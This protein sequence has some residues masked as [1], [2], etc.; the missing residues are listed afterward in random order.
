MNG[1]SSHGSFHLF[2]VIK[3]KSKDRT[4]IMC[5]Q[6]VQKGSRVASRNELRSG[7]G[8]CLRGRGRKGKGYL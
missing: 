5:S 1:V 4:A 3:K 2:A 7:K 6:V 8:S